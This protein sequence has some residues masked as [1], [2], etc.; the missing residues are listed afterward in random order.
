MADE[1]SKAA[2]KK[3]LMRRDNMSEEDA[4][5]LIAGTQIEIDELMEQEEASLDEA[6]DI[7]S[8]NL[9]LEPDYLMDFL[10]L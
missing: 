9:S 1:Y 8:C 7:I 6:E 4:D 2:I 3:I 5:D 10:P